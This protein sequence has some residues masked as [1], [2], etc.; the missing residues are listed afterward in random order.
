MIMPSRKQSPEKYSYRDYCQWNDGNRYEL[1]RG[2][3]GAVGGAVPTAS[4]NN[5][6]C[7]DPDWSI[8]GGEAL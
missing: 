8:F 2:G 3:A 5:C 7:N 6:E 4:K 1:I